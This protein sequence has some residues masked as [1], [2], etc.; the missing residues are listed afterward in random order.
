MTDLSPEF[1]TDGSEEI[2]IEFLIK[3]LAGSAEVDKQTRQK[4]VEQKRIV[5]SPVWHWFQEMDAKLSDPM[6]VDWKAV[7]ESHDGRTK[8]T[9]QAER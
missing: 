7:T 5:G 9:G 4:I 3:F 6:N 1:A 2:A 8:S